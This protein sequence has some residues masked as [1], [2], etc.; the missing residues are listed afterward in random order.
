MRDNTDFLKPECYKRNYSYKLIDH[1]GIGQY[2]KIGSGLCL[3]MVIEKVRKELSVKDGSVLLCRS[4]GCLVASYFLAQEPE[5]LECYARVILWVPSPFHSVW[6]RFAK[7]KDSLANFNNK[8][9]RKG[10]MINETFWETTYPI[11]YFAKRFHRKDVSIGFGTE[12]IYCDKAFAVYLHDLIA[13]YTECF[14][15][16]LEILGARHEIKGS[17][18]KN[19]VNQYLSFIFRNK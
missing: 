2:P 15:D 11:E 17:D 6:E 16:T 8:A 14:V 12:D 7:D 3:P 19:I 9:A 5:H 13:H 10:F 1:V 18:D 4:F